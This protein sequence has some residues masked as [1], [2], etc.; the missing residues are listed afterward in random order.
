[1]T[2][3]DGARAARPGLHDT[4]D[5]ARIGSVERPCL[6]S[7]VGLRT[8]PHSPPF[9]HG[10]QSAERAATRLHPPGTA[11]DT[12]ERHRDAEWRVNGAVAWRADPVLP[13]TRHLCL[14]LQWPVRQGAVRPRWRRRRFLIGEPGT[15]TQ[16]WCGQQLDWSLAERHA[17]EARPA[18]VIAWPVT[19]PE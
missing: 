18:K 6:V 8:Q 12:F 17:A 3:D 5:G 9:Q 7:R 15:F 11:G 10:P 2:A 4:P 13:P 14:S 16:G 19:V 1:V